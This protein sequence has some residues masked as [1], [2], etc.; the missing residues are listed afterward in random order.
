MAKPGPR[1]APTVKK[2]LR[3]NPG[4]RPLLKDEPQPDKPAKLPSAPKHLCPVARKE[5]R[6]IGKELHSM[7]L[8]TKVDLV[9]AIDWTLSKR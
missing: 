6:R 5:W 4:R 7:G 3:G 9:A 8:V 2:K 1:P